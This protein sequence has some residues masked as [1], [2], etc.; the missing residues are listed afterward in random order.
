MQVG[1][2]AFL[3]FLNYLLLPQGILSFFWVGEIETN[4][5][6]SSSIVERKHPPPQPPNLTTTTPD[7]WRKVMISVGTAPLR[8]K[9][10]LR[11]LT[12]SFAETSSLF[13]L[14][15]SLAALSSCWQKVREKI[16]DTD[17][18]TNL[19]RQQEKQICD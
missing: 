13:F 7:V 14:A 12:F 19:E 1:T 6:L 16:L 15:V 9:P 18:P 2:A 3:F 11:S 5:C 8:T 17:I 4:I 10:H